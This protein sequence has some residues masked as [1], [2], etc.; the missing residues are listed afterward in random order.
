M[1]YARIYTTHREHYASIVPSDYADFT[2]P[3]PFSAR[4]T[5]ALNAEPRSVRLSAL[6]GGGGQWYGFGKMIA[7]LCAMTLTPDVHTGLTLLIYAHF[8]AGK[9]PRRGNVRY[10]IESGQTIGQDRHRY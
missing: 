1:A 10:A 6:V 2:I 8:Q 3:S 5:N 4:V 7:Q 9:E